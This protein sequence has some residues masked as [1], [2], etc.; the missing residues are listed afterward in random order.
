MEPTSPHP[1]ARYYEIDLLRFVAAVAVVLY[2]WAYR[3]YHEGHLSP[4]DYPTLG[5]VCKYG[6]L[7]VELFFLISGYVILHSAQG[8]TLGQFVV[9]RV[10]RLYPAY[11][12]ACTLCFVAMRLYRPTYGG[13]DWSPL[14]DVS[15]RDYCY[16]LSMLQA[17]FGVHDVDGVYWTLTVEITFYFLISLLLAF[18][19][20]GRLVPVLAGWL[21]YCTLV[22]PSEN[23]SPFGLLLFPRYAPFFIAGMLLYL[24]QAKQ[25]A[26]WQLGGLLLWA[27]GLSAQATWADTLDKS[28]FFRDTFSG[29][30]AVALLTGSYGVLLLVTARRRRPGWAPWLAAAGSL[31]YPVYLLHHNMGYLVL[32][33]LG[34]R[35]EKHVLLAAMVVVLLVLAWLLHRYVERPLGKKLGEKM[36]LL[37]AA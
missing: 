9:S 37:A 32:L 14:F 11:W 7:G 30:L 35:I 24:L 3:G 22:G 5:Q 16:N 18:G 25:V 21:G 31:T 23:A 29:P 34:G 20:L 8:K 1:P 17:F 27:Y 6:Y 26:R 28:V 36:Q 13:A 19:W 4:V 10:R 12:V 2:H 33:H 15:L